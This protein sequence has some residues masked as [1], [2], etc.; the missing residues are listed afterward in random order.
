MAWDKPRSCG[1]APESP[2]SLL[3]SE[4]C[5]MLWSLACSLC[6]VSVRVVVKDRCSKLYP[7]CM[8]LS[9]SLWS[10]RVSCVRGTSS[11]WASFLSVAV[12]HSL[13][14]SQ[15]EGLFSSQFPSQSITEEKSRQK[16]LKHLVMSQPQSGANSKA[17]LAA[18]RLLQWAGS[19]CMNYQSG[20]WPTDASLP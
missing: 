12:S 15:G 17:V 11:C 4:L 14:K 13:T 16:L 2:Q 6:R 20:Q 19:S 8:T 10:L 7:C 18:C 3:L 1:S 9:E 5:R